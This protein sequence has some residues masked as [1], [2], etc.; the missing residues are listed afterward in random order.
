MLAT[1]PVRAD[2]ASSGCTGKNVVQQAPYACTTTRTID[3]IDIT[4]DLDVD[5][6]GR[7]VQ[8]VRW[9]ARLLGALAVAT[10]VLLV[11]DGALDV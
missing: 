2:A 10:S 11:I 9:A 8:L 3:G 4:A 1:H 7:A 6:N 5:A